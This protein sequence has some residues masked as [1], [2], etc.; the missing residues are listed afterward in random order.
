MDQGVRLLTVTEVAK[1]LSVCVRT[2]RNYISQG[3][4][5]VRRLGRAVRVEEP[6]VDRFIASLPR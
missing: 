3:A 6:E 4:L 2:V 5:R 1:R